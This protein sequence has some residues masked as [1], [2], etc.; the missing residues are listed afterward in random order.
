VRKIALAQ[1]LAAT[2]EQAI[3]RTLQLPMD[4]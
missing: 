4:E 1:L 2:T 3:L